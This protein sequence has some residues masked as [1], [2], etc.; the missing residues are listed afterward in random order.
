MRAR[1][2]GETLRV[3]PS[4]GSSFRASCD[5]TS[6][7]QGPDEWCEFLGELSSSSSFLWV[8]PQG[9]P[10]PVR[11]WVRTRTGT[12]TL[13][14]GCPGVGPSGLRVRG[15]FRTSPPGWRRSGPRGPQSHS[16][17]F[18]WWPTIPSPSSVLKGPSYPRTTRDSGPSDRRETPPSSP[19][20][21]GFPR[22]PLFPS[23][24]STTAG[25]VNSDPGPH[26]DCADP[27]GEGFILGPYT[28]RCKVSVCPTLVGSTGTLKREKPSSV[29]TRGTHGQ[30]DLPGRTLRAGRRSD[31]ETGARTE[32]PGP[33]AMFQSR[34]PCSTRTTGSCRRR[35]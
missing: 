22:R 8:G 21:S 16:T 29:G 4:W 30:V 27:S 5:E 25:C 34:G 1:G 7:A 3:L 19:R 13:R 9:G 14:V 24:S 6:V 31:T 15:D 18:P 2:P 17:L 12:G 28:C 23:T 11:H 32:G 35:P 10:V 20:T 26:R 33:V